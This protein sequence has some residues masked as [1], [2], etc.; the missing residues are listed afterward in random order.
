MHR[1]RNLNVRHFE[2]IDITF[3]VITSV[4]NFIQIH[5]MVQKLHP[6]HKFKRPRFGIVEATALK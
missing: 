4:K 2:V 3:N 6:L 5:Q 1:L